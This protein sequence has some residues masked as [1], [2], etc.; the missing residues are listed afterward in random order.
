MTTPGTSFRNWKIYDSR[1]IEN[2]KSNFVKNIFF[3]DP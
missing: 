2:L 1:N 3:I